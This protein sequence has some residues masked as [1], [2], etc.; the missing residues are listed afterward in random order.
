MHEALPV[1][2]LMV[3]GLVTA[4][5]LK[6]YQRHQEHETEVVWPD[7]KILNTGFVMNSLASN[8]LFINSSLMEM[9][10]EALCL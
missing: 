2:A 6:H 9:K 7:V 10:M 3:R 8:V 5:P 4:V 1:S